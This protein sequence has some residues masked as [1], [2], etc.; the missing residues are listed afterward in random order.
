MPRGSG[1]RDAAG[2]FLLYCFRG[3]VM[4]FL[5]SCS[6]VFVLLYSFLRF[7]VRISPTFYSPFL[8][9][10]RSAITSAVTAR[11]ST[12]APAAIPITAPTGSPFPPLLSGVLSGVGSG[13]GV[14]AL[15]YR[16]RYFLFNSLI[17]EFNALLSLLQRLRREGEAIR[18][19]LL[20][21]IVIDNGEHHSGSVK[22]SSPAL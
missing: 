22:G 7:K 11:R 14:V 1:S 18:N 3:L 12:H 2:A 16:K 9:F 5:Q 17:G 10:L 15:V 19:R 13:V 21:A 20:R 4:P 8:F 6:A